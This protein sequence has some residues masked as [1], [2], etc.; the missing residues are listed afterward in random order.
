MAILLRNNQFQEVIRSRVRRK[1]KRKMKIR[2]QVK[3]NDDK[4]VS[5]R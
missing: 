4:C 3:T 5:V 1:V 2:V